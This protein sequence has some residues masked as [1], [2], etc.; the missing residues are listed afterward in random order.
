MLST[1]LDKTLYRRLNQLR[2]QPLSV[3]EILNITKYVFQHNF[4]QNKIL[5]LTLRLQTVLQKPRFGVKRR[6]MQ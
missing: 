2:Y 6:G 5:L 4:T 1:E 3:T